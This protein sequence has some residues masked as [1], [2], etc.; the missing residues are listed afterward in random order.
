MKIALVDDER[1][2][3]EQMETICRDYDL[4]NGSNME[5]FSFPNAET[6]LD[7]VSDTGFPI[8][9]MDIYMSGTDGISAARRLREKDR[10][11]VIIFLTASGEF[12]PEAFSCH[13]FEYLSKP[14][15]R[16][17]VE[18]CLDDAMKMLFP[19]AEFIE[20]AS[21]RKTARVFLR[22]IVFVVTDA[23]YLEICLTDGT[24]LRCRMTITDFIRLAENDSRFILANRGVL[25]NAEH[26][27]SFESGCCVMNDG[28]RLPL[29]VKDAGQVEQAISRYNFDSIRRRQNTPH[30]RN[31]L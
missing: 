20:I 24:K 25:L 1:E 29:R 21:E 30:G 3:L 8:V 9:F 10:N 7:A 2:Y 11:C 31:A 23:H 14:I 15:D 4:K 17:R 5:I 26:I 22:D 18:K 28:T 27:L 13:A 19:P 12:M 16:E 6:F